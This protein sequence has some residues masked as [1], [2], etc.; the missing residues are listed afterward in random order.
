M[1]NNQPVTRQE[2]EYPDNVTLLNTLEHACML[3]ARE[4]F[5][6]AALNRGGR[7]EA[8]FFIRVP[9]ALN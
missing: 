8:R 2:F 5:A 9:W 4:H 1:R 6:A 3:T 7:M